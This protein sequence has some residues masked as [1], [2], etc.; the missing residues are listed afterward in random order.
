MVTSKGRNNRHIG[1]Q[2]RIKTVKTLIYYDTAITRKPEGF[3]M[4]R[5]TT[6]LVQ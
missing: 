2:R 3:L 4:V 1:L 5:K 6:L